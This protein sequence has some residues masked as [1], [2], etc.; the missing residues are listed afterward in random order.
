[1]LPLS[2]IIHLVSSSLKTRV[3]VTFPVN[4]D[5]PARVRTA[6][7]TCA[8]TFHQLQV[9]RLPLARQIQIQSRTGQIWI[10]LPTKLTW[11]I[12]W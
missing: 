9:P 12:A 6:A 4:E 10:N 2:K 5:F 3:S 1:M 11:I 7:N 8:R